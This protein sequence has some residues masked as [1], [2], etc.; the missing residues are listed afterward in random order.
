[1]DEL[2]SALLAWI[3][4]TVLFLLAA[5]LIWW[6]RRPR[7]Q[8]IPRA[9]KQ[10][11]EL[12]LPSLPRPPRQAIP[13]VE[14]APSRLAR[15]KATPVDPRPADP[16]VPPPPTPTPPPL[17]RHLH[18]LRSSAVSPL[19]GGPIVPTLLARPAPNLDC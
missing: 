12:R 6:R 5:G 19:A 1:M 18:A 15:I 13:E 17:S 3:A 14:I 7:H 11:R 2:Q 16:F 8:T 4:I 10:A 9:P